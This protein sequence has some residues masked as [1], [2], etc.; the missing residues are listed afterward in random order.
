MTIRRVPED[1][2]V[3]ERTTAEFG[4]SLV[5]EWSPRG[6]F[7]AYRMR[8]VS[9]TTPEATVRLAKALGVPNGAVEHAGLKD[10]H[11]VT[12]QMVTVRCPTAETAAKLAESVD[13][14]PVGGVRLGFSPRA[15][16]AEFIE[17]NRFSI[18]VR[19]LQ[20]RDFGSMGQRKSALTE[21]AA[22]PRAPVSL[23]IVNYFGDQRFG[24]ARHGEGF[25]AR[26]LIRGEFEAALKLL[27]A[28][29]ARKDSG[30]WRTFTRECAAKWGDWAGLLKV[31]PRR[32][33][34]ACIEVLA[35]GGSMK[36]AFAALPGFT[37][38]IC[39]EAYQSFLWN[40]AARELAAGLST[41]CISADDDFG[42]MK[43]P[44]ATA[45]D[46]DWAAVSMPMLGPGT[47]LH[48]PWKPAVL[49]VL[50]SEGLTL[51]RLQIPGLRRPVFGEAARALFVSATGFS[52]GEPQPDEY[53]AGSKLWKRTVS[54]DLP[55]GAYAT[56][57]LRALGQ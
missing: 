55:R 12:H 20:R 42:E 23:R 3:E 21:H 4:G 39:V 33:E 53:S 27:I 5:P 6:I 28:T 19:R 40:A 43:F 46:A 47:F 2:V 49:R 26:H 52:I 14:G 31:L 11:A 36:D 34:R 9:L 35:G 45:V 56:V 10:K 25:A 13:A 38:Q 48:E 16:A 24:S 7:A 29:P 32:A 37:Q 41:K 22:E 51:D 15:A 44:P 1:F 18:V 50:E 57:V 54:F 30:P 17:A 8:K